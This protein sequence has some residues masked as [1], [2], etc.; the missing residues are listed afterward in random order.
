MRKEIDAILNNN[1]S[2]TDQSSSASY[3]SS[4]SSNGGDELDA[5]AMLELE[6]F[7]GEWTARVG[8]LDLRHQLDA[9]TVTKQ[10]E[11][12]RCNA[13]LGLLDAAST[14]FGGWSSDAHDS[15]AKIFRRAQVGSWG[16]ARGLATIFF[17]ANGD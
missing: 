14:K 2:N 1:N 7:V 12:A 15:F 10:Q 17:I 5:S 9:Q 13:E 8:E 11:K 6:L 16:N 4:S 3:S